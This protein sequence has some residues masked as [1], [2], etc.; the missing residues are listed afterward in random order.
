VRFRLTGIRKVKIKQNKTKQN[1]TEQNKT[2]QDKTKQNTPQPAVA[3][4]DLE[5]GE[6]LFTVVGIANWPSY[7]RRHCV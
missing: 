5:K 7:S 4:G 1:K 2:E 3:R 6:T